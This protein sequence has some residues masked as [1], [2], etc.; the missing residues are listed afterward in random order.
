MSLR[1][2][3]FDPVDGDK[4]A[5]PWYDGPVARYYK[6]PPYAIAEVE[7]ASSSI[8]AFAASELEGYVEYLLPPTEKIAGK[9]SRMVFQTALKVSM[10]GIRFV[11]RGST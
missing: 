2:Q 8:E 4:T 5:Y 7:Q 6:C 9:I 1:V 10:V 3:R 11:S